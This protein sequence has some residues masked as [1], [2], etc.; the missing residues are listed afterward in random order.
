MAVDERVVDHINEMV[1]NGISN[2]AEIQRNITLFIKML[3]NHEGLPKPTNRRFYPSR[4]DII[5]LMYRR[6]RS[7][8]KGLADQDMAEQKIA[9]WAAKCTSDIW[10][11]RKSIHDSSTE[12]L[13]L[14]FHQTEWQQKLFNRYGR[15]IVFLDA[16]YRSVKH[17]NPVYMVYVN[18]NDGYVA[19]GVMIIERNDVN[20]LSEA[21]QILRSTNT[22]W[23]PKA[24]AV[25]SSAVEIGSVRNVFP[26]WN[27]SV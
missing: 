24:F 14:V 20:S 26:G 21:L 18:T 10:Y 11:F 15:E 4:L 13:L 19:V 12:Q 8:L 22:E 6:R 25:G 17:S 3:F 9:E 27:F 5:N 7:S 16:P 2:V 23:S 1:D